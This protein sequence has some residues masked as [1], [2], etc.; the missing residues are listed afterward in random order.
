[1]YR[2]AC[3]R[4]SLWQ[5]DQAFRMADKQGAVFIQAIGKPIK[6]VDLGWPLKIDGDITEE[7]AIE[8]SMD[9]PVFCQV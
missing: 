8:C 3:I 4:V 1:M 6:D 7:D 9:R 2:L 5:A